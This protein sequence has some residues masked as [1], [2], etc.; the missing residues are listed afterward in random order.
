MVPR[1]FGASKQLRHKYHGGAIRVVM[2][3]GATTVEIAQMRGRD[4][5][6]AE[7]LVNQL[8]TV[9]RRTVQAAGA[10]ARGE[11]VQHPVAA[12]N[13]QPWHENR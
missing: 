11:A 2:Q 13:S 10:P 12:G 8:T 9:L 4:I 1:E 3:H 5:E 7:T 6:A